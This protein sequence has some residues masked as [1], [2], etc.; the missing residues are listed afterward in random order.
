M[1]LSS[2]KSKP[3]SGRAR[4]VFFFFILVFLA[5]CASLYPERIPEKFKRPSECQEFLEALDGKVLDAGVRD[6]SSFPIPGF[7]YLRTTRFLSGVKEGL[8]DEGERDQ[9]LRWMQDLDLQAREREIDKLPA[10][11]VLPIS[12][13]EGAQTGRQGVLGLAKSCSEKLLHHDRIH[14][15]FFET[16]SPLAGGGVCGNVKLYRPN[17]MLVTAAV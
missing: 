2:S 7:P 15:A 12:A 3:G 13:K 8:K 6:A 4:F 14:P 9:W 10:G 17:T 1:L 5:G 16:L 11:M